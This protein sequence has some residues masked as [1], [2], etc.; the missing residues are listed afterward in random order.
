MSIMLARP[1]TTSA[2]IA[3]FFGVLWMASAEVAQ[4]RADVAQDRP[5]GMAAS[6]AELLAM[7]PLWKG[8]RYADGRPKFPDHLLQRMKAVSIEDAWELLRKYGYHNQFEG[9]WKILHKDK[10][11]VGRALT[12]AYLPSRPDLDEH[13]LR[14]GKAEARIGRPNSWPIDMLQKG[15]VYVADGFGKVIDGTLMGDNLG[16]AIYAR[17]GTGVVFHAGARDLEGLL[18]IDGFNAFVRDWDPSEIK[19]MVLTSINRPIRIGRA[20]VLPGDV[21]LAKREG[22]LAI[23]VH[24]AEEVVVTGE[25]IAIKD[26][27]GHLRLRERVYTPGQIDSPWTNEIKADFFRWYKARK[28][29]PSIPLEEIEK[30]L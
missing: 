15:D 5:A 19:G 2:S 7:T 27:F 1:V 29:N 30:H 8:E 16:T 14:I 20:V 17:S 4:D 28:N 18:R 23:P 21:I 26:E 13:I 24:L 25:I 9:G 6:K 11:F 22:V 12:A 10:P 3:V